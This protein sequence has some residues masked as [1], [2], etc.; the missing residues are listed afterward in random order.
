[1][2]AA[3]QAIA[4]RIEDLVRARQLPQANL[5]VTAVIEDLR[6]WRL[7]AQNQLRLWAE[8]PALAASQADA[9]RDRL[10][11]RISRLEEKT[12]ET[13]RGIKEGQISERDLENLYRILGAFRGLSESGIA[14]S[15][16]AEG[17]DWKAWKEDRF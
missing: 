15:T 17:I 9:M 13:L 3:L 16:A 12:G 14:F 6:E 2:I 4:Y 7:T 8:D 11:A 1:M 10:L 5:L